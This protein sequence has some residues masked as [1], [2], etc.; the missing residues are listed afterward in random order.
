MPGPPMLVLLRDGEPIPG[1][2]FALVDNFRL[3]VD[4]NWRGPAAAVGQTV[5]ALVHPTG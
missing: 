2:E 1:G 4:R 3:Q 5:V